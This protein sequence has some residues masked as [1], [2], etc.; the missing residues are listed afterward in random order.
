M[1]EGVQI[2]APLPQAQVHASSAAPWVSTGSD[3]E[4]KEGRAWTRGDLKTPRGGKEEKRMQAAP[5]LPL[6]HRLAGLCRYEGEVAASWWPWMASAPHT[7]LLLLPLCLCLCGVSLPGGSP[8]CLTVVDRAG[9]CQAAE[10]GLHSRLR[11]PH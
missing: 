8:S 5:P 2:P 6:P 9:E 1:V 4:R 7:A 3:Q 11:L 10:S